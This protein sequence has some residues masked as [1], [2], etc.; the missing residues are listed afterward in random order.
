MASAVIIPHNALGS[1]KPEVSE[2]TSA[3][4]IPLTLSELQ[5]DHARQ[6]SNMISSM[7]QEPRQSEHVQHAELAPQQVE[8]AAAQHAEFAS[9]FAPQ[10]VVTGAAAHTDINHDYDAL[11]VRITAVQIDRV[12]QELRAQLNGRP[13]SKLNM[14]RCAAQCVSLT[15]K[16][17]ELPN[18]LKKKVILVAL[19]RLI[20]EH[21][22]SE[23]DRDTLLLALA[24]VDLGIDLIIDVQ[25]GRVAGGESNCCTIM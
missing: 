14:L 18:A 13:L 6:V 7:A 24:D 22:G 16:M 9:Q 10:T 21:V 11:D 1:L 2:P 4:V 5:A 15:R 8:L 19:E 23:E 25:K 12:V 17:V 3:A 20:A